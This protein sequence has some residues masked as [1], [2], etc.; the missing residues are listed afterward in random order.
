MKTLILTSAGTDI[1][2][3]IIKV[4]P[5]DPSGM[6]LAHIIT[7]SKTEPNKKYVEKD[8]QNFEAMGFIVKD[9]DIEGCTEIELT[10]IL[11]GFDVICV[12]GGNTFHLLKAAKESGFEKVVKRLIENDVIYI[13]VSAGSII[14]GPSIETSKWK[15]TWP[16]K[17]NVGLKNLNGFAWIP[18]NLFVHYEQ[19][20]E[21]AVKKEM[22]S[23]K[24]A[25]RILTDN[26]AFLIRNGKVELIGDSP[27]IVLK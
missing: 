17:N 12:Q 23:S 21:A 7:A 19:R 8:H 5:R 3:E 27:E 20:W 1:K 9:I 24:F 16:D 2:E 4:L 11:D 13:G 25:T 22:A 10:N 26:Q 6:K 18:F 14:C 15:G